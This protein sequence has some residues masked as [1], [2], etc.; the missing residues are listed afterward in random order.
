VYQ[1]IKPQRKNVENKQNTL[2]QIGKKP[3]EQVAVKV[4][5]KGRYSKKNESFNKKTTLH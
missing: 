3:P 2:L 1:R 4:E 5:T